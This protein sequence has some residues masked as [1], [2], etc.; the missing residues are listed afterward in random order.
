MGT[1]N[2]G[3]SDSG[4]SM[5][6]KT[7][8]EDCR[9]EEGTILLEAIGI[10]FSALP[11]FLLL[12]LEDDGPGT[13][14]EAGEFFRLSERA[15]IGGLFFTSAQLGC[16][17]RDWVYCWMLAAASETEVLDL[18][19]CPRPSFNFGTLNFK[20]NGSCL[21][22]YELMINAHYDSEY[23]LAESKVTKDGVQKIASRYIWFCLDGVVLPNCYKSTT[24][25][26]QP[27]GF[28][29]FRAPV[30]SGPLLYVELLSNYANVIGYALLWYIYLSVK[31][32]RFCY[33]P[34]DE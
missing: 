28:K 15:E 26:I 17:V 9:E 32:R 4:R 2:S 30:I 1:S 13:M 3:C 14:T 11:E 25:A 16:M 7:R 18:R 22:V 23:Y 6:A 27:F 20:Q 33:R 12:S 10:R 29:K 8:V 5:A 34:I 19:K 31:S 21:E 24:A